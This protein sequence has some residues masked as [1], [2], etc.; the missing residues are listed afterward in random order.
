MPDHPSEELESFRLLLIDLSEKVRVLEHDNRER[1]LSSSAVNVFNSGD[2][3]WLLA[4]TGLVF[5]MTIP[6]SLRTHHVIVLDY[7]VPIVLSYRT[8]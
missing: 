4:A 7:T 6:G 8:S 1:L 2:T 3:A 5:F